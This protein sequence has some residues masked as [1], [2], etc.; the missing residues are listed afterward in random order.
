MSFINQRGAGGMPV[1]NGSRYQRGMG[2]GSMFK[3]FFRWIA[4]IVKTHAVPV[5]KDA[6]KFVGTEAIK[7]AANITSDA[8][9][10]KNFN[11]SIKER[12]KETIENLS[13]KVTTVI[14]KGGE[15]INYKK[16][17]LNSKKKHKIKKLKKYQDIFENEFTA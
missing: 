2:L 4:P 11:E 5:I 14:Q 7:T 8:I 9:D 1:F 10:G 17:K 13:D 16:R 12:A 3:S 6:A 15:T